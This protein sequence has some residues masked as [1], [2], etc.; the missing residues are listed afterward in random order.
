M[1][2]PVPLK[3]PLLLTPIAIGAHLLLQ[4]VSYVVASAACVTAKK[5]SVLFLISLHLLCIG[6]DEAHTLV[7]AL[8]SCS[9]SPVSSPLLHA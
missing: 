2:I 5:C 8:C 3:W 1:A 6:M 7:R 4:C 9:V